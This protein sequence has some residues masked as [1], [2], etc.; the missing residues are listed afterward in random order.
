MM[1][2]GTRR[3][4]LGLLLT[5]PVLLA[6]QASVVA[7]ADQATARRLIT[8]SGVRGG[9]IVHV[10]CS[11]G[12]LT[13]ALRVNDAYV[14]QG[15]DANAENVSQANERFA[16]RGVSFAQWDGKTLPY[17]DN[18]VNLL[19]TEDGVAI[20]PSEIQRVLAPG[21][22]AIAG[23]KRT[24]KPRPDNI[25]EWTHWMRDASGNGVARDSVVGPPRHF[26]WTASPLWSK[27]HDTVLSTSA[28]VSANG[29]LFTIS[30]E[31]KPA[32]IFSNAYDGQWSLVARDA[33]SGVLLWK[34]P[35]TDWGWKAWGEK[36]HDR[37]AQPEQLPNRLVAVGDRVYATLGFHDPLVAIDAATGETVRTYDADYV[38]EVIV[39]NDSLLVSSYTDA[40]LQRF[41][42]ERTIVSLDRRAP[43]TEK[44]RKVAEGPTILKSVLRLNPE[45]G[46]VVWRRDG[47][48]GLPRRHDS[49]QGYDPIYLTAHE[50]RVV[51]LSRE[52]IHCLDLATGDVRWTRERPERKTHIMNLGVTQ[53]ENGTLLHD[54]GV[55]LYAQPVGEKLNTFHSIPCDLIALD[56]DTGKPLWQQVCGAWGWGS[57]PD[58]FAIDGLVWFH[59]HD[60]GKS[61]WKGAG[62]PR[63]LQG[64]LDYA[65]VGVDLRS[66][67][68]K[69]ELP[70][71]DIFD[72]AHHHRCYRNKA[73]QDFMLSAR[74]GTE[75]VDLDS[76]ETWI[77]HWVRSECRYG[78]MPAN[79]L[80]Y[81]A[82]HPCGCYSSVL[83]KGYHALAARNSRSADMTQP[84]ADEQR[85]TR[86]PA[87]GKARASGATGWSTFRGDIARS[88]RA[89]TTIPGNVTRKWRVELPGPLT[90]LSVS[91]GAC[92][93]ASLNTNT[94]YAL[95]AT[96]GDRRWHYTAGASVD[97]PPSIDGDRVLFG[98]RDG[99]VIC[100]RASDGA[101]V[102]KCLAAPRDMRMVADG[103][104]ESL[105][106]VHGS[107]LVKQGETHFI[108]GR[109]T[110]VD[111]GMWV[112]RL[113][114][115]TGEL[116]EKK[117]VHSNDPTTDKQP[118]GD[119]YLVEGSQSDILVSDGRSVYQLNN[120]LFGD[121]KFVAPFV[122]ATA[123]FLDDTLFVR[124]WWG[125]AGAG[126]AFSAMLVHD[127]ETVYGF[128]PYP[129]SNRTVLHV[130]GAGYALFAASIKQTN[131]FT[132]DDPRYSRGGKRPK[133]VKDSWQTNVDVYVRAMALTDNTLLVAGAPDIAE[134]K[135]PYAAFEGRAGG[136]LLVVSKDTGSVASTV[137]LDSPPVWDGLAVDDGR[138]Y[139]SSMDGSVVCLQ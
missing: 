81:S 8:G 96:T 133:G 13:A 77:Q 120:V 53:S 4:R 42:K 41:L 86:G 100:L 57:P 87:F 49:S 83:L 111:D 127:D 21:G 45:T 109:S 78:A 97:T 37:F 20:D 1:T 9:L 74:R 71:K 2:S 30:N 131:Q 135:D 33:F 110:Y 5:L 63:N 3:S 59:R 125:M 121:G 38:D 99:H 92:Y 26:Q 64:S 40:D 18:L 58:V 32:S 76:G 113:N 47:F 60:P 51:F 90:A 118:D 69:R 139:V 126:Q 102:W 15:L 27:H 6:L 123:G 82:P 94:V 22:V 138:V 7:F 89:Q 116:I 79:G 34:R 46:D 80:L 56:A 103:R 107:V 105:W 23:G 101:L 35:I 98:S 115:T 66:G 19:V 134:P 136:K 68:V 128:R 44:A 36:Y 95:D 55:V 112:Y 104:V 28:M 93:V 10:G 48:A 31:E 132:T 14:V 91:R 52:A 43:V 17:V 75:L 130:V 11:D 119:E 65:L 72:I 24:V 50:D 137:T 106:P 88:G 85:L 62:V 39:H 25:D 114:A 16:K 61:A 54:D 129:S 84:I 29:R 67:E 108:A 117:R 70:T 122:T 12:K 124:N 73:T